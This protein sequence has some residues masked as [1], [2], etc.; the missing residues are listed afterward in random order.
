VLGEFLPGKRKKK[1]KEVS[2]GCA[3]L[4]DKG[5][6]IGFASIKVIVPGEGLFAFDSHDRDTEDG[7]REWMREGR[8]AGCGL[9]QEA[10]EQEGEATSEKEKEGPTPTISTNQII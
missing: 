7:C 6:M 4:R 10:K 8:Q 5:V 2:D 3:R 1:H 9:L